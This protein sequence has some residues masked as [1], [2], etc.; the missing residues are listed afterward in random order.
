MPARLVGRIGGMVVHAEPQALVL[1]LGPREVGAEDV[2]LRLAFEGTSAD[3]LVQGDR[4]REASFNSFLGDDPSRWVAGARSFDAV[5]YRGL[6]PG[7]DLLLREEGGVAEYDLLLEPAADPAAFR[8][9][10]EGADR[11]EIDERGA[12]VVHAAGGDLVQPL[13]KAF[14]RLPDGERREVG[15]SYR[16]LDAERF[17]IQVEAHD[18][19][20]ALVVDPEL[21]WSTYIGSHSSPS[22]GDT[23]WAVAVG[24]EGDVFASGN[25]EGS[26]FPITTSLSKSDIYSGGDVFV[27]RFRGSDGALLY[28]TVIG[29]TQ[30]LSHWQERPSG[31]EVDQLGFATV[32]G[33]TDASNFPTTP[34]AFQSQNN[35]APDGFVFR[36]A[37]DGELVYSTYLGGQG[38]DEING[39]ALASSGAVV[40][41]GTPSSLGDFPTTPGAWQTSY[42]G[43]LTGAFVARLDAS[44][45]TL[46]WSTLLDANVYDVALDARENV[47]VAGAGGAGVA[48][49]TPGSWAPGGSGVMLARFDSSGS[50]LHWCCVFGASSP[51][52]SEQLEGLALDGFGNPLI[53]GW[54][55]GFGFPTTPGALQPSH[56]PSGQSGFLVRLHAS[57]SFPIYSTYLGGDGGGRAWGVASDPSGVTTVVASAG[58]QFPV[59]PGAYQT[60]QFPGADIV[61]AR[62]PPQGDALLYATFLGGSGFDEAH[63]IATTP[64]RR[65]SVGGYSTGGYPTTP[66]AAFT[67]YIGGQT[68]AVVTTLD[69]VLQGLELKGISL[70]ACL[71]PLH[72]NGTEM[73][74][75]GT[76]SFAFFCSG[77][78]PMANGWLLLGQVLAAPAQVGGLPLWISPTGPMARIPVTSDGDGWV[79]TP[80]PLTTAA[81]GQVF[82]GQYLFRNPPSC[83]G[84][85]PWSTSNALVV[86]VQ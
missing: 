37:P 9:S 33:R 51:N 31:I 72:A 20:L 45:S 34:G 86:T 32:A 24:P 4:L 41:G 48:P 36:L 18:S 54:I 82:A 13:P 29:G 35:G 44:G 12:L 50:S 22:I 7:V 61:V 55:L 21:L 6:Y 38:Y 46:E 39:L 27:A 26:D 78:P 74:K 65:V 79:E 66:G 71:G 10:V 76:A 73:P 49:V 28:S 59:T 23:A 25:T 53:A 1:H 67:S 14:Q 84:R 8:V 60:T 56:S 75:S 57:G 58:N 30:G 5:R 68:D 77:A 16:L 83:Q 3:A 2:V 62:L 19:R 85:G 81:A 64:D 43:S 52:A 80:V 15:C 70:P 42:N 69:L 47:T 17:G 63:A 11:I 40:V